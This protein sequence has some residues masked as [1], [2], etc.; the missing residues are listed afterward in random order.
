[1]A[2]PSCYRAE[3]GVGERLRARSRGPTDDSG[4]PR[5]AAAGIPDGA[6][7]PFRPNV[8]SKLHDYLRQRD[9]QLG[10]GPGGGG[11]GG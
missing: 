9:H 4:A 1:M 6:L 5:A 7:Q 10:A 11:G 3:I 8:H 2:F